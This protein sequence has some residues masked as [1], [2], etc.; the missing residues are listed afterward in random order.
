MILSSD[1]LYIIDNK[2][3]LI[4]LAVEL[5]CGL[6]SVYLYILSICP[7]SE[8][9]PKG[10]LKVGIQRLNCT[11]KQIIIAMKSQN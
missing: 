10:I 2:C 9:F 6:I 5:M 1:Y 7:I 11:E 8:R 4:H 3:H